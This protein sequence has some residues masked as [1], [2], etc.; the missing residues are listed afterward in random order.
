MFSLAV[1]AALRENS[2]LDAGMKVDHIGIAVRSLDDAL[3]FYRDALGLQC[4]AVEEVPTEKVR[5]AM[6]PVG[7][8]RIELLEATAADS[9][10][11]MFLE[12]RAP[13]LHHICLEV[14]N[15]DAVIAALRSSGAQFAGE[16]PRPGAEGSRVAFI[17]PKS[18]EGVLIEL[19]EPSRGE[20]E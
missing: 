16:A 8:S 7:E 9:P 14:E 6:L 13:G 19:V 3:K 11:A 2:F 5:V 1:F 17:H 20:T 12:R 15:I 18:A 10:I 4:S